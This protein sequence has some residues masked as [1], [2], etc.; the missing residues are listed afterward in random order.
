[1]NSKVFELKMSAKSTE[2][3][4]QVNLVPHRLIVFRPNRLRP[5]KTG[6]TPVKWLPPKWGCSRWWGFSDMEAKSTSA[7]L[8]CNTYVINPCFNHTLAVLSTVIYEYTHKLQILP[9]YFQEQPLLSW[10]PYQSTYKQIKSAFNVVVLKSNP[11]EIK[12]RQHLMMH[13]I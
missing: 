13:F 8:S 1:M 9:K 2:I 4:S 12:L 7:E 11:I 10:T 5:I 3:W 6:S